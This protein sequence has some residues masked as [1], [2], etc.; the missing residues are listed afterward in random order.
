MV[1]R[2][3]AFMLST[4]TK[5]LEDAYRVLNREYFH[6]EL[7]MVMITI[8]SSLKA[9][10]HCTTKKI[11]ASGNERYYELN[12]SAEYLSRPIENVLATLAHEMVH[13]Y[14]MEADIKDTSNNGRYHNKRFKT[15]AEVRG[16]K[17]SYAPTI[18]WSV[19]EPTEEFIRNLKAWGLYDACENYRLGAMQT[20]SSGGI[21]RPRKPSSTRKYYCPVCGNSV[22]ATKDVNI[23]CMDCNAQ[24]LK[25]ESLC[26]GT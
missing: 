1:G 14:C 9:Y 16:L 26:I 2:S 15:E 8:Q 5:R 23:L 13:I 18:G 20:D 22:R 10:G 24:M 12:L 17:I 7:P 4:D 21:S 6:G 11:W 3:V 19:T 25:A